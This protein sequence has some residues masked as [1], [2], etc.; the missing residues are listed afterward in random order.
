MTLKGGRI[1]YLSIAG[2]AEHFLEDGIVFNASTTRHVAG[3]LYLTVNSQHTHDTASP[4][5]VRPYARRETTVWLR[6]DTR[7]LDMARTSSER[8]KVRPLI[9]FFSTVGFSGIARLRT[10][11]QL[12]ERRRMRV[13]S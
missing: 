3:P 9:V 13:C 2:R 5:A 4:H 10:C 11:S 12:D 7:R 1:L 6:I 8:L